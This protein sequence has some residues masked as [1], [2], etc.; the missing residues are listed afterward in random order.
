MVSDQP[1]QHGDAEAVEQPREHV[2]ALVVGAEPVPVADVQ[3]GSASP[4]SVAGAAVLRRH[5][6]G[7]RRRRSLRQVI[8]DRAVGEA[9]RRP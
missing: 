5:R 6:P 7:R 3:S 1:E 4:S 9:D 8:V 2:A